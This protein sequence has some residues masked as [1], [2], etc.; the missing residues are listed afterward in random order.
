VGHGPGPEAALR[1]AGAV[2]HP[3]AAV[4]PLGLGEFADFAGV[5]GVEEAAGRREHV[6]AGCR[7]RHSADEAIEPDCLDFLEAAAVAEP[8]SMHP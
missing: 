2:V 8:G 6:P 7:G 4:R 1:V 3:H 5:V